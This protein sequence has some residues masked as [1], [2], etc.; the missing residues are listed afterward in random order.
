MRSRLESRARAIAC[1]RPAT[2][3]AAR[4]AARPGL[5]GGEKQR[6]AIARALNDPA[7]VL[8]DEATGSLDEHAGQAVIEL[9]HA[10]SRNLAIVP[11]SSPATTRLARYA[12]TIVRMDYGRIVPD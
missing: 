1:H 11:W 5:S 3:R 2:R 4:R 9:L 8:A 12:T 7:L 6:V 10:E